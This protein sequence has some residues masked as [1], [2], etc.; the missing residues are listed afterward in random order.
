MVVPSS[1]GLIPTKMIN[2]SSYIRPQNFA[3]TEH[4]TSLPKKSQ[5][6]FEHL[7]KLPKKL[8][9]IMSVLLLI[10][11]KPAPTSNQHLSEQ[12]QPYYFFK[13]HSYYL[14]RRIWNM[15]QISELSAGNKE[16]IDFLSE[17]IVR[18]NDYIL[19]WITVGK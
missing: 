5:A 10:I 14:Q 7:V 18:K 6:Q 13:F 3:G 12:L 2:D 15:E 4:I 19:S 8:A 11:G 1:L 9:S 17:V 16:R